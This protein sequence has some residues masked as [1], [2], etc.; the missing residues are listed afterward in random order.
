MQ[1]GSITVENIAKN[2]NLP[3]SS[4]MNVE[5]HSYEVRYRR[6]DSGTR[7]PPVLVQSIFG[8]APVNGSYTLLDG[9]FMRPSQFD[10]QP[11]SD[12][13]DFGRDLETGS[14][15]VQMQVSIQFFGKTLSGDEVASA[16]G[17]FSIDVVP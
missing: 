10:H 17:Y 11:L 2:S 8:V 7:V 3:T 13:R 9:P 5:I 6:E 14:R 15:V 16:P 12:L 1:I 4:L